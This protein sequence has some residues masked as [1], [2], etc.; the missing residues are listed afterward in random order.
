MTC[1]SGTISTITILVALASYTRSCY[2]NFPEES[3]TG[4]TV[5]YSLGPGF[6]CLLIP[7]LFKPIEVLLNILTPVVR[8]EEEG[9]SIQDHTLSTKFIGQSSEYL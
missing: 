7:Q 9:T 2:D 6:I 5:E 8:E 4:S 1:L 3:Y